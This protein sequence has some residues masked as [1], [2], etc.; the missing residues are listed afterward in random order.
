MQLRK[1]F[2]QIQMLILSNSSNCWFLTDCLFLFINVTDLHSYAFSEQITTQP[3][4]DEEF[5]DEE[6]G[7]DATA[8]HQLHQN[9]TRDDDEDEY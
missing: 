4:D 5:D 3:D 6:H 9:R 1:F 7:A 8:V 2:F